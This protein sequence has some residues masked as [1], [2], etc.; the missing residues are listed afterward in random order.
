MFKLLYFILFLTSVR[1]EFELNILHYNDFHA[2][3]EETSL[4]GGLCDK[5]SEEPCIGGFARLAT[6]VRE[7]MNREQDSILLN[8][9]DS[10][11][12]TIWYNILRWNVT[13]DFMNM[14]PHDAHVLGNHE[15]DNGI[16][17]AV[18]YIK[19]LNSTVVTANMI[20]DDE[21]T[22]QGIYKPSTIVERN[23]KKIGII[24][25]IISSTDELASTGK[26]RFTDEVETVKAEAEKLNLQG[27][28]V[29]IVL[30]HC[31]LDIDREIA[32][33]GGPYIDIIVG[34]HSHTLLYNG[35]PTDTS[36]FSPQGPYPI[37]V[38]QESRTVLIV[39]AAAHTIYL[40]E[41]KLYFDDSG[42]LLN[43]VGNPHYLGSDIEQAPDV[44]AKIDEYIPLIEEMANT[45]VGNS[46]VF[47]DSSCACKECNLGN[48]ICDAFMHSVMDRAEGDNWHYAHFCVINQGGIR[49]A[50][51]PGNVTYAQL[52]LTIPF[53]NR[54]EV[55]ELKGEH[56]IEMLEF[57]VANQPWPGARM[58]QVSGIRTVFDGSQPV[59]SRVVSVTV[60]CIECDVPR[61]IP[62]DL[63]KYYRV[64]SQNFIGNGGGGYH[65]IS[66][67]RRNVIEV[68]LD[69]EVVKNYFEHQ[70]PV[71]VDIDGR[72]QISDP[73]IV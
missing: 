30:S 21:P 69:Y 28:D 61:Y 67:N 58:L 33:H 36:A 27:V 8:G 62:L 49:A 52:L 66:N 68:G 56:I 5:T 16:E 57:S 59:G 45:P 32:L 13:Q 44:L 25:V 60:R 73:C 1:G 11:Q 4:S 26:L 65:M 20:A 47:L 10:F 6:A 35:E 7:A 51:T 71:F 63:N 18:P 29:I 31:G 43:W 19:A 39:Q 17:G 55:F 41:I 64:V 23:G 48:L 22:I 14:L 34:G 50:I 53:E 42:N 72:M 15:F 37:V 38:E 9:G 12:G 70:S 40:G 54:V 2:R 3:F 24:G 46:L